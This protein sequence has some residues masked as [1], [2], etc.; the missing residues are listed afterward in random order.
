[1]SSNNSRLRYLI[2]F[3]RKRDTIIPARLWKSRPCPVN[4]V[5]D[6][7]R[8]LTVRPLPRKTA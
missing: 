3:H 7:V 8:E 1:V 2:P 5:A 6:A 4:D